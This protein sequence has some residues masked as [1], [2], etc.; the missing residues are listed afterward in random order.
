MLK[1]G[2]EKEF[3]I[4]KDGQYVIAPPGLP[5]DESGLLAEARGQAF[6]CPVEAV[7]SLN[8]DIYKLNTKAKELSVNLF[9]NPIAII[10]RQL[11]VKA[12]RQFAKG[13]TKYENLYGHQYHRNNR[14]ENT[15]GIHISFTKPLKHIEDKVEFDYFSMFDWVQIF[16][17]LDAEF[18]DEIKSSKRQPGFYELKPDGRIEYRSLPSNTD[19]NKIIEILNKILKA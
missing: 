11:K 19:L 8:A 16:R 15:A 4:Q 14:S 1:I 12:S 10:P 13:L 5:Y 17:Q 3:F 6:N 2:L 18:K 7:Y 9:D